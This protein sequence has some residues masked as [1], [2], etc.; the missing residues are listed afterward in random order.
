MISGRAWPTLGI[1]NHHQDD[2]DGSKDC[3]RDGGCDQPV[4]HDPKDAVPLE[5]LQFELLPIL[6]VAYPGLHCFP[7]CLLVIHGLIPSPCNTFSAKT[8]WLGPRQGS[9]GRG[10]SPLGGSHHIGSSTNG[11]HPRPAGRGNGPMTEVPAPHWRYM[12][13]HGGASGPQARA[14]RKST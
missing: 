7:L 4:A 6:V 14:D 12:M 1:P 2:Q 10:R 8:P 9:T 3:A 11:R 5:H 13:A